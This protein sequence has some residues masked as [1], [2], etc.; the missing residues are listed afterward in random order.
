MQTRYA[1]YDDIETLVVLGREFHERS[2]MSKYRYTPSGARQHFKAMIDDHN[3]VIIMHDN[4]MIGGS[5]ADYPFCEMAMSKEAF[6]YSRKGYDG[7]CLLTAWQDW[8]TVKSASRFNPVIDLV[9]CLPSKGRETE[10]VHK[11]IERK[12]YGQIEVTYMRDV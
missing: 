8:L 9:S 2:P 4:G 10:I 5:I 3:S 12:G 7:M 6:W 1:T 11:L